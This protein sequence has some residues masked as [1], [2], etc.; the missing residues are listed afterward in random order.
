LTIVISF[1]LFLLCVRVFAY[2]VCN[3]AYCCRS[4]E[5]WMGSIDR[6]TERQWGACKHWII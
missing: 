6:F 4:M 3:V 2:D 5:R 1:L